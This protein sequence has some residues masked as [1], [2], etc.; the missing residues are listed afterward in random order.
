VETVTLA[1]GVVLHR[2]SAS[3]DQPRT[4]EDLLRQ[5]AGKALGQFDLPHQPY[6]RW[7][8]MP[9]RKGLPNGAR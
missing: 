3:Y 6:R 8:R 4:V 5:T 1:G 7:E 2:V 9:E